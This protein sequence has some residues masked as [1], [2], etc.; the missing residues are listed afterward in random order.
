MGPL[1]N[2]LFVRLA[3]L[4]LIGFVLFNL[5]MAL[6]LFAPFGRER[7]ELYRY[8]LARQAAAIVTLYEATPGRTAAAAGRAQ[9]ARAVGLGGRAAAGAGRARAAVRRDRRFPRRLF[10]RSPAATCASSC[11]A[12]ARRIAPPPAAT[13]PR[14]CRRACSSVS[15]PAATWC[16]SR[17]AARCST[18]FSPAG[19]R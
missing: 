6:A 4:L 9:L 18:P 19:W 11:A 17:R 14:W 12:A 5:A 2:T 13:M 7:A 10:R 3:A 15:T 8:P 1:A 16:W